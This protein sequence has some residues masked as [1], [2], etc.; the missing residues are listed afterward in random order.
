MKQQ[1]M[2]P[3]RRILPGAWRKGVA[4]NM[5]QKILVLGTYQ[6]APYHPFGGVDE[7]L[8]EIFPDCNLVCTEDAATLE[9]LHTGEFAGVICYLDR[10]SGSL[11]EAEAAALQEFVEQGGAL[12]VLHNGI[13]IQSNENLHQMMGGKFLNHPP[14]EEI[15]FAVKSH[16]ITQGCEDFMLLEEPYQFELSVDEKELLL[17]YFYRN[18]EYPAGWSKTVGKGRLVFLTPGHTK[19]TFA[20]AQYRQLIRRSMDWCME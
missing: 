12:L 14:K 16:E 2:Y 18:R 10:W 7:S 9:K 13:C 4:D 19:E 5:K 15:R 8:K 1:G 3:V 20:C 6:T 11:R 17:T